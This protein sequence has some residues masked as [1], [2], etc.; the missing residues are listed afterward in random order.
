MSMQNQ[1]AQERERVE[2]SHESLQKF[3][4][5]F[6]TRLGDFGEGRGGAQTF[7]ISSPKSFLSDST[8]INVRKSSKP[9]LVEQEFAAKRSLNSEYCLRGNSLS[10][11]WQ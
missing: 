2:V 6:N 8:A 9:A 5:I 7:V 11:A 10:L 4:L 3:A 1:G